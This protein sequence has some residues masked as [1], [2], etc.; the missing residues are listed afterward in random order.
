MPVRV[1]ISAVSFH[2]VKIGTCLN[3]EAYECNG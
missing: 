3:I 2:L 1:R